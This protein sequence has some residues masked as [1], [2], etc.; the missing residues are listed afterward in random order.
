MYASWYSVLRIQI[1]SSKDANLIDVCI[2]QY[3]FQI[4]KKNRLISLLGHINRRNEFLVS[5]LEGAMREKDRRTTSTTIFGGS[6]Q[7]HRS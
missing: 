1:F 5:V 4:L 3:N 6:R 7:E 2:S